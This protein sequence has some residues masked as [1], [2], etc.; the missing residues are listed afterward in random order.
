MGVYQTAL[1]DWEERIINRKSIIPCKP[2]N[3]AVAKIALD[4]FCSL[5][6]VD[7][8]GEPTIGEVAEPWILEF[9]AVIFGSY[10]PE[11]KKRYLR[12]FYLLI[13]KKNSKSSY[14]AAIMLT[15]LVLNSRK[16]GKLYIVA[17]TKTV[18]DNSF[19]PICGMIDADERLKSILKYSGTSRKITHL[20]TDAT[21]EVIAAEGDAVTGIKGI[22]VL[23]EEIHEFGKRA[24]AHRIFREAEGGQKTFQEGFVIYLT[25]HSSEEPTGIHKEKL[26]YARAVLNGDIE[27]NTFLPVLY[28]MPRSYIEAEKHLDPQNWYITNP[29]LGKSVH[30]ED[31]V[32]DYNKAQFAGDE[33]VIDFL[34]KHVN[35]E[36]GMSLAH[37]GWVGASYWEDAS[38][39]FTLD[40]LLEKSE[41]LTVGVDGGG[42]EDLLGYAVL[43]RLPNKKWWLWGRAWC[44]QILL[45]RHKQIITKLEEFE[46]DGH[47]TIIKDSESGKDAL[48]AAALTKRVFDTGKLFG[49]GFDNNKKDLLVSSF[50]DAGIPE[51]VM[52]GIPQGYKL[53]PHVLTVERGLAGGSFIP[54][55]QSLMRWCVGNAKEKQKD[56]TK[57]IVKMRPHLKID[58]LIG[59]Y[60]ATALMNTNPEPPSSKEPTVFFV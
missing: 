1:P 4:I 52:Y 7:V 22:Y 38:R 27:D 39:V 12:Y 56:T 17:P 43:G 11:T 50:V 19:I 34:A 41:V 37:N 59:A 30:L 46:N 40:E 53:H 18:A 55:E 3:D 16:Q 42:L 20:K 31:L 21:L 10:D 26:D 14:A 48:E 25:T 58:P 44:H 49:V 33:Q 60:N 45:K 51:D 57:L 6:L 9:V 8:V 29:N 13:S 28:E 35:V 5:K 47:L 15:A 23:F 32:V 54:C 2:H 24:N 36:V